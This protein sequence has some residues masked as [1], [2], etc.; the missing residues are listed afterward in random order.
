MRHENNNHESFVQFMHSRLIFIDSINTRRSPAIFSAS[1]V[2]YLARHETSSANNN[3]IIP[4]TNDVIKTMTI[5]P[6]RVQDRAKLKA[7][8]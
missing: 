5:S 3:R 4:T 1:S 6:G 7:K 2:I 8:K